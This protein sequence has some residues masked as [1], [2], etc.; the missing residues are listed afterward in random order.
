M[1]KDICTFAKV[2]YAQIINFKTQPVLKLFRDLQSKVVKH[3]SF[4]YFRVWYPP[5]ALVRTSKILRTLKSNNLN[6]DCNV[7]HFKNWLRKQRIQ[8][9]IFCAKPSYLHRSNVT[10]L[11][12]RYL[13]C[14]KWDASSYNYCEFVSIFTLNQNPH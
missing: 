8:S 11:R 2:F 10:N 13:K 7:K 14:R 12:D 6:C 1:H 4:S 3:Y 5:L 9:A